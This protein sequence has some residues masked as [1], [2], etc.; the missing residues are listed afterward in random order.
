MVTPVDI[1]DGVFVKCDRC[2]ASLYEK[3]MKKII[4]YAPY[5]KITL[6]LTLIQ[7]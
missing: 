4:M 5:V 2:E 3:V 6:E 1:P 7:G